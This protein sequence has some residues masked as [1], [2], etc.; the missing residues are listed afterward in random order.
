[1][2][3]CPSLII[4]EMQYK[5]TMRYC[6]TLVRMTIIKK[7]ANN[8]CWRSVEKREPSYTVGVSWCSH[9]G[10]TVWRLLKKLKIEQPYDPAI[11]LLGIYPEKTII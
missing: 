5:T 11:P 4:S 1:M 10:E 6:L 7:S 9:Y 8:K 2:K 3:R